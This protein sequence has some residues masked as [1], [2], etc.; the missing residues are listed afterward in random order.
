[1]YAHTLGLPRIGPQR[2]L[3]K[4]LEAYW[5]EKISQAELLKTEESL[6]QANYEW[7]IAKGFDLITVGDYSLYDQVLDTSLMLGVVPNRVLEHAKKSRLEQMFLMARGRT[8]GNSAQ[9]DACRMTKWFNTNYHFIV[10]EVSS[11]TEFTLND[12]NLIAQIRQAKKLNVDIKP[13]LLGPVSWLYLTDLKVS[14]EEENKPAFDRVRLLPKI[15]AVYSQLLDKLAKE[16]VD[17]VQIDEPILGLELENSW[18]NAF[19]T[20]YQNLKNRR[21]RIMLATYFASVAHHIK[22][23]AQ[24]QT[25]GVH[26]DLVSDSAQ[27]DSAMEHLNPGTV[28]SL[29]VIDGR[30]IW[31]DDLQK[32]LDLCRKAMQTFSVIWV[33]PSCSLLHLPYSLEPEKA[34]NPELKAWLAFASEKMDSVGALYHLLTATKDPKSKEI[35]ETNQALLAQRATS[36]LVVNPAV[37]Q[38]IKEIPDA[39]DFSRPSSYEER[40]KLQKQALNLPLCPTTT[41]GSFPQTVEVRKI[42]RAYKAGQ[43]SAADYE[44]QMQAQIKYTIEKQEQYGLDVL[45]HGE[46]ERTDMVEYFGEHLDGFA[47]TEYAWVQS[48]GSRCVKPPIIYGDISRAKP[49][50]VEYARYAQSLSDKPVKGMLTGPITILHWSFVRNDQSLSETCTQIALALADE[51]KDLESAGIKIIQI[52]EPALREGLPLA[53]RDWP[54][55]ID[56]VTRCF[57]IS[58]SLVEDRTQIHTHM[59]YSSFGDVIEAIVKMDADVISIE[60]AR[61]NMNILKS[62]VDFEYPNEIGLGVY[63]IHSP[64]PPHVKDMSTRLEQAKQYIPLEKIWINPDCGLKTRQWSEVDPALRNMVRCASELRE[65]YGD[66][67]AS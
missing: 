53:K 27:L 34:L 16:G 20:T 40:A 6:R 54:A 24:L 11:R 67:D 18:L 31:L 64:N 32:A 2:E 15:T 61:S 38:R 30:N 46:P 52:D 39:E 60:S 37:R 48:Y 3:K 62:F 5:S 51:V 56:W 41:I 22:L 13:V 25:D 65:K 35:L 45:V 44:K 4:A 8:P 33:A 19:E 55:Y 49:M 10:P 63:D 12:D 17:W 59:C 28:I 26:L 21:L 29:G 47:F 23:I 57:R 66:K 50:T 42:R 1:M 43:I 7:Q 58:A 14:P 9:V 36:E